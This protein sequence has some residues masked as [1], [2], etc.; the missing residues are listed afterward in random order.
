MQPEPPKTI[1]FSSHWKKLRP[2]F[3]SLLTSHVQDVAQ[4]NYRIVQMIKQ[5]NAK[6]MLGE[7]YKH[8]QQLTEE[9]ST[10]ALQ[11]IQSQD[12]NILDTYIVHWSK[13]LVGSRC[14][15]KSCWNANNAIFIH[16]M[17]PTHDLMFMVAMTSWYTKCFS[18]LSVRITNECMTRVNLDRN[19]DI[20][21]LDPIYK[22]TQGLSYLYE[23]PL[24]FDT[25]ERMY[26]A[27]AF[28]V[29]VDQFETAYL[30][31]TE[32][33]FRRYASQAI[34]SQ[35][36]SFYITEID[37]LLQKER[38]R[39]ERYLLPLT[40]PKMETALKNELVGKH[41]DSM[42]K[43]CKEFFQESRTEDLAKVYRLLR[44]NITWC[45]PFAN[46]F[47]SYVLVQGKD[48]TGTEAVTKEFQQLMDAVMD[49]YQKQRNLA[50]TIFN[51]DTIFLSSFD[52]ACRLILNKIPNFASSLARYMDELLKKG[53]NR[54]EDHEVDERLDNCLLVFKY[55]TEK[56]HF[57][58]AYGRYLSTRLIEQTS[59][60][61]E[62]EKHV[63]TKLKE[64]C[65]YDYTLKFQRM[66]NDLGVCEEFNSEFKS[67]PV[68]S[69]TGFDLNV[70]VLTTNTWPFVPPQ[71][72][73]NL[74]VEI[75]AGLETLKEYYNAKHHGRKLQWLHQLGRGDLKIYG[76]N[77][78]YELNVSTF[79]AAIL[80]RFNS[81][82]PNSS[83]TGVTMSE[84]LSEIGF[85]EPEF[86]A[87]IFPLIAIKLLL[88]V[89]EFLFASLCMNCTS[90]S[91]PSSGERVD[92]F[93][94]PC[95]IADRP[96][97]FKHSLKSL[98]RI[99]GNLGCEKKIL[100]FS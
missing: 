46:M 72:A 84:F 73:F 65:G 79:Q 17:F 86:K 45:Q 54:I 7:L 49:F 22:L 91:N 26:D 37:G 35:G 92:S 11:A 96:I 12:G 8:Y 95:Y 56:D 51:D 53:K 36:I 10:E 48:I 71:F 55:I 60:G 4:L 85:P 89:N 98:V 94:N 74:P 29:Y 70:R 24:Y 78:P 32:N 75:S 83:R 82:D 41:V 31:A 15:D 14:I 67:S 90:Y 9:V 13:Y 5:R 77:K 18:P 27:K 23:G 76:M 100:L 39:V 59:I 47:E 40:L 58:L 30:V 87:S 42:L 93:R 69:K 80:L 16:C 20:T 99:V 38:E 68:S 50:H 62:H 66:F 2:M 1:K 25:R 43:S 61:E 63:I 6:Q 34:A 19:G 44:N 81:M 88:K 52:K 97:I 57:Q 33:F 21:D 64:I 3:L 28:K